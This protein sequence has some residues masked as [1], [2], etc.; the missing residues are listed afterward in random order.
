MSG[1]MERKHE[2]ASGC[3]TSDYYSFHGLPVCMAPLES[4]YGSC[5]RGKDVQY[6]LSML[7]TARALYCNAKTLSVYVWQHGEEA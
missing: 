3:K 4:V 2:S 6:R 1:S 7:S 5:A